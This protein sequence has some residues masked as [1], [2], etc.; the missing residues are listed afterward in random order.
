M[1]LWLVR[2]GKHGEDE[3]AALS[4][5]LAIIGWREM[6]DVSKVGS[7]ED[8]KQKHAEI[9]PRMSPKAVSNNAAQLWAFVGR[10]KKSDLVVLP[11]KTRP[12]V[13][14]GRVTGDY[15]FRD[16]RHVRQ[17]E[18][19]SDDIPRS[20]FGQDLMYSFGA[21]MTVCQ[22]QRNDAEQRVTAILSRGSDPNLG[23]G[24]HPVDPTGGGE[25][26]P[27]DL[28]DSALDQ[29]RARIEARF[30]GHE[31]TRLVEAILKAEG[32]YTHRS[33]EGADG[34]VDIVAGRGAMGLEQPRLCVQV[35]SGGPQSDTTIRELEGVMGRVGAKQGLLVSWDGFKGTAI[36]KVNEL[37]F[38][39]R[40][41]DS[42][43][44]MDA[45]LAN[46]E[47]LPKEIQAEL[48]LKRIWVLVPEE[49]EQ[50]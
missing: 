28:A 19:L 33:P 30:K 24:A 45:L 8:M 16:G 15:Q 42:S 47:K 18:W 34:G 25:N 13:A 2:A 9:Y 7:Y 35:K 21:Y 31:L 46:Y 23:D 14:I 17:V 12:E 41:W 5:G 44:L 11:L 10:I 37:F 40:L 38:K 4:K 43:K 32:Y 20:N 29:I 49:Q 26:P 3:S 1:A 50:E 48:P 22:I 6:P 39:V 27:V 36:Q